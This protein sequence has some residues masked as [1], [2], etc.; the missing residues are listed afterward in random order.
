MQIEILTPEKELFKGEG[1]S[2]LLPG[3]AGNFELLENHAPIIAA[4]QKGTIE[5]KSDKTNT[6]ITIEDG[7]ME[8]IDNKVSILIAGGA[9]QA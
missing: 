8:C 7:F 5:I 4:L 1:S 6:S 2:I 9:I 3:I